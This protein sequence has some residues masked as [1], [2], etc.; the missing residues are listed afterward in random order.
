MR[1]L[2]KK[3]YKQAAQQLVLIWAGGCRRCPGRG[4]AAQCCLRA[5]ITGIARRAGMWPGTN[6]GV[7]GCPGPNKGRGPGLPRPGTPG[8]RGGVLPGGGGV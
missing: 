4:Q 2:K 5:G 6:C 1:I 7:R 3:K 8:E